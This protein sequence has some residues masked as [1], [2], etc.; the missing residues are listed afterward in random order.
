VVSIEKAKR[1]LTAILLVGVKVDGETPWNI[2][3]KFVRQQEG[4]ADTLRPPP[5]VLQGPSGTW[6][7]HRHAVDDA[8]SGRPGRPVVRYGDCL[9][10]QRGSAI[11]TDH[12]PA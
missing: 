12:Y 9:G 11:G 7:N 2:L 10:C 3:R 4:L 5:D 6:A 8:A 1:A